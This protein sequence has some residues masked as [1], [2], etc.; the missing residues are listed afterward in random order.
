MVLRLQDQHIAILA[1]HPKA[2]LHNVKHLLSKVYFP[3]LSLDSSAPKN[4][5][6]YMPDEAIES[7]ERVSQQCWDWVR[8]VQQAEE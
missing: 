1:S 2:P 3:D 6:R 4:Y 7:Y 5:I 8:L